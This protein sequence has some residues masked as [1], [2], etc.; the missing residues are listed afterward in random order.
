MAQIH[1]QERWLKKSGFKIGYLNACSLLNKLVDVPMILCNYND[2][3]HVFGFSE[4]RFTDNVS[5]DVITIP[6]YNIIRKDAKNKLETGIVAYIHQSVNHKRLCNFDYLSIECIWIEIRLKG[7]KP[8][9]LGFIY[10][11]PDERVDWHDRFD[12]MMEDV[13]NYYTDIIIMGDFN[14]DLMKPQEKWKRTIQ[15]YNLSQLVYTP[16]RVTVNSQTLIDHIY[17]TNPNNIIEVSVP[18][19]GLSDHF[20]LC[21]TW[22]KKGIRIPKCTHKEIYFRSYKTFVSEQFVSDLCSADF[23]NIYQYTDPDM[24]L[25]A[26]YDTFLTVFDKHVPPK[27]RRVKPNAKPVWFNEE[28]YAAIKY[29]DKLLATTGKD[30]NFKKQRNKITAMK[31]IAK[32][33][34]FGELI[35][36]RK[37]NKTIWKAINQLSGKS[38]TPKVC[39][40]ELSADCLNKHFSSIAEKTVITDRSK[41]NDLSI[42]A[43]YCYHKSML[44]KLCFGYLSVHEVYKE[45]CSLKQSNTRG[46][47]TL[48]GKILQISAPII[49][50]H[51]TYIYNLC[52]DKCYYPQAFKEAKVI[53]ILKSGDPNDP[54]NYRPISILSTLSKPLEKYLKTKLLL[55]FDKN[56]L[57]H[58]NQSGFRK[59]HSCHTALTN[60]VEKW[61]EN[62]NNDQLT[63]VVFLDFTKAFDVIDHTLLS[64]KL[65]LYGLASKSVDLISSF[66]SNRKQAVK[67][68]SVTSELMPVNY[69]VPQGSILGPIIFSIY[70]ND[71]PLHISSDCELFA[72]DT[73][74]HNTNKNPDLLCSVLQQDINKLQKWTELNHMALHPQKS[75]FMLVT[76]RQKRQNMKH[77]L[78]KLNVNGKQLENVESYKLLGLTLDNNLSWSNHILKLTKKLSRKIFQFNRIKHFL[79]QH[80]RKLFFYAFIQPDI[81]YASTCWDLCSKNY[82]KPLERLYKRAVK[83]ILLK[84]NSPLTSDFK[85]LNI[86]P[87]DLRC[88][89]NKGILM[90]KTMNNLTPSYLREKFP[91]NKTRYKT[92]ILIPRPRTDLFMTSF[93]YSGAKLWYELSDQL[94]NMHSLPTFKKAFF[95]QLLTTLKK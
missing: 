16:T 34:Y 4:T 45:L 83:I 37:D 90:F 53:P 31:R 62:I 14:I 51:L 50:E 89:F 17:T 93:T 35:S 15:P 20:P 33:K 49:S 56:E 21:L 67:L 87:F 85:K 55:H 64:K 10:R 23:S 18:V 81:D 8:I 25:A 40:T 94:K 88:R 44:S 68:N 2:L 76:T 61:H 92:N 7:N 41:D 43:E 95:K 1:G 6:G 84:S 63:G 58:P 52:I 42:L 39:S 9:L 24:A 46:I 22:S 77:T 54:S 32:R 3:F 65:T 5:D 86:L 47:D 59:N 91:L 60:L 79:D 74:V 70:I 36:S 75:K 26:W 80:T 82:I 19:Y 69:G 12:Q 29:R 13:S 30:L 66:L 57:F 27:V 73:T 78:I 48:D 11:N 38:S 72:D 71:L 28:I